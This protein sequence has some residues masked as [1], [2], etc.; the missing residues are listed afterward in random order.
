MG[1][2]RPSDRPVVMAAVAGAHGISGEVRLK[3]FTASA[4]NLKPHGRFEA[5]GRTLT[6]KAVRPGPQGAV[7]RFAEIG[8]RTAAEGL[9]GTLL[10]VPRSSLPPL[11]AG[12]YY[13]HDLLDLPVVDEAGAALGQVVGVEN[14]GASDLLEIELAGGKRVLV[15]LVP[16][17]VTE[18]GDVVRVVRA[19]VEAA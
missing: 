16:D 5:G 17:A 12:E 4:D 15:P 18:V 9:R 8:D 1:A 2:G 3:L 7:A 10:T 13:W 19:W 6:L 11:P 14:Y